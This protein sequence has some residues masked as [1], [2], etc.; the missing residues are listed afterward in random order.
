MFAL[1][2][3]IDDFSAAIRIDPKYARA[4]IYRGCAVSS[5]YRRQPG[6][7]ENQ[8]KQVIADFE[9]AIKIS[10]QSSYSESAYSILASEYS[11]GLHQ[12][13]KAIEVCSMAVSNLPTSS[14]R[15]QYCFRASLYCEVGDH[16]KE[17]NDYR[18]ARS[19]ERHEFWSDK[20]SEWEYQLRWF[21]RLLLV[22][23]PLWLWFGRRF[24]HGSALVP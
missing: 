2:E 5:Y 24:G 14:A 11:Y 22:F 18:M 4:Y 1:P 12:P 9:M 16:Q 19:I 10:P 17:F 13:K 8:V 6:Y 7:F 15:H 3:E 23:L 21:D 20:L